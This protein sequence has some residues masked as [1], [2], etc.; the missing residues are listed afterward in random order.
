MSRALLVLA[1]LLGAATVLAAPFADPTRP[2]GA[3]G[4]QAQA[5][6]DAAAPRLQSV[7]IAP[8]RRIA[9]INGQTVPLGGMYAGARLVRISESEVVL[10]SGEEKQTLKLLPE[11]E[12]RARHPRRADPPIKREGPYR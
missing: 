10:Q 2:P 7:L 3:L 9:V 5:G 6:A 8:D 11:V 12:R 1:A 4:E